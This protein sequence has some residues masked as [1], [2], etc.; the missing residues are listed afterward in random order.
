MYRWDIINFLIARYRY[1][2]YLEIG[3]AGGDTFNQV[4]CQIKHSVDPG[5]PFQPTFQMTSDDFFASRQK[6]ENPLG[7]SSYDI[8]F[9]DGLHLRE[10]VLRDVDNSLAALSDNGIIIVHDCLPGI[11]EHQGRERAGD[12]AWNGDVWKAMAELRARPDLVVYTINTDW[13]CGFIKKGTQTPVQLPKEL[14]WKYYIENRAELL[15]MTSVAHFFERVL[16]G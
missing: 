16:N 3:V 14:D 8:V 7:A 4:K 5:S 2:R 6:T 9:V 10:Q 15:G 13:G 11:V 12:N 1:F